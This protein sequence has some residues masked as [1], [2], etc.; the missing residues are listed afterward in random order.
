MHPDRQ[1]KIVSLA[2]LFAAVLFPAGVYLAAKNLS[3]KINAR[4]FPAEESGAN[5][6]GIQASQNSP[7]SFSADIHL[8]PEEFFNSISLRAKAVYVYDMRLGR[9]LYEKNAETA[10]PLASLTKIMTAFVAANL[11]KD[12]PVE[13]TRLALEN[14]TTSSTTIALKEGERWSLGNLLSYTLLVSSNEG[15]NALALVGGRELLKNKEKDTTDEQDSE[16]AF[17]GEMNRSASSLGLASM[18]FYN[19]SGLDVL[20]DKSG[21]YGSARDVALLFSYILKKSPEIFAGTAESRDSFAKLDGTRQNAWN[22]NPL[23]RTIPGLLASKTGY[24]DLAGGNLALALNIGP[25]RPVIIVILGSTK[26]GRFVDAEKLVNA[27][28]RAIAQ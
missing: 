19:P 8:P 18:K 28:T 21:G 12:F 13:I 4:T 20:D 16:A 7:A 17:V 22:T 26:D 3:A 11:S 24:T 27:S 15:A 6:D 14:A 23:V 10:R 2:L 5:V 25:M 1:F 9:V